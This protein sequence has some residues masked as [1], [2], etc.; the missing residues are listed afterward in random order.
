MGIDCLLGTGYDKHM[1]LASHQNIIVFSL[2]LFG[3]G[4]MHGN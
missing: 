2:A 4:G 1:L 3:E